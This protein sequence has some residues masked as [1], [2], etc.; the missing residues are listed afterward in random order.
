MTKKTTYL[1]F[2]Q[3]TVD[4]NLQKFVPAG[5]PPMQV[6]VKEFLDNACD[7]AERYE[8]GLVDIHFEDEVFKVANPGTITEKDFDV[9]TNFEMR[10][11][12]K[13]IKR[14]YLRNL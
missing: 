4:K 9:I 8:D 10:T 2:W 12:E 13:Y 6:V 1:S 5:V 11:S 7:A 3:Y 14:T